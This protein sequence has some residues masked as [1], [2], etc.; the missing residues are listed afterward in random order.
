MQCLTV[1]HADALEKEI[2]ALDVDY[3]NLQAQPRQLETATRN[4][5]LAFEAATGGHPRQGALLAKISEG[6]ASGTMGIAREILTDL[7]RRL[8]AGEH[9]TTT[10]PQVGAAASK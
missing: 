4:R 1:P 3:D 8:T 2:E 9:A 6:S 10:T 5:R 7:R